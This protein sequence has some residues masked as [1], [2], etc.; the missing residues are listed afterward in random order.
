MTHRIARRALM[1]LAAGGLGW[2]G[3]VSLLA[4]QGRGASSRESTGGPS[5]GHFAPRA[6]RAVQICLTGGLSQVDSFDPKPELTRRSGQPLPAD[7]KPETFFGSSGALT[8]SHWRFRPRGESGLEISDLFPHLGS[9]ADR[10]TVIRSMVAETANHTPATFQQLTG[11]RSNGF[12]VLGSWVS[13]ALGSESD[14]LPTFVV[15][16]DARSL[17]SGGAANWGAGFLPARHQGTPFRSGRDPVADLSLPAGIEADDDAAARRLLTRLEQER[18]RDRPDDLLLA[19]RM[20][21]YELAARMQTAVPEAIEFRDESAATLAEYG[22]GDATT[23]DAARRCLLTRRLL[24]RGVRFIQLYSGGSFGGSPRHGWDSHENCLVDHA[25]EAA[26]IDRPI[27]T[28][29]RDLDRRGLLDE[30]LILFTTEFGRTPFAS[31]APGM[32]GLGRDHNPEGFSIWMAGAG[33]RGGMAY[34]ATDELGWKAAENAVTW[35]DLH[36][37]VLHLL[38]LDHERLTF[39]HDGIERRLTNVHGRVIDEILA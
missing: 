21:S 13:Y 32:V 26:R 27:A 12:P 11:F 5:V 2:A 7:A 9:V 33:L 23:D 30:T 29:I 34:G 22:V 8:G 14:E 31:G 6:R 19:A 38:G 39:Y 16:P 18:M 17:P 4:G 24:E 28:L 1:N 3:L 15:L 37:T 35:P 36:A 20:R 10:L 25:A